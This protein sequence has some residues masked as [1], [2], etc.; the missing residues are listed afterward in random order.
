MREVEPLEP[1][2]TRSTHR[3]AVRT[4]S[5]KKTCR[6]D[7]ALIGGVGFHLGLKRKGNEFFTTSLY[8]VDRLIEEKEALRE[9]N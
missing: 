1:S 6:A 2:A 7:L 3:K 5:Q 4:S 9:S 8:K